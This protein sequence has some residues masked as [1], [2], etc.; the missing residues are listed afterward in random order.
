MP[1]FSFAV[2]TVA[3]LAGAT[4]SVVGFGIGSLLTPLLALELGMGT[5]VAAV[6][7]PRSPG[8]S[9]DSSS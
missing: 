2:L 4:A 5:A 8:S 9:A 7:G 1:W 3:I 6:A